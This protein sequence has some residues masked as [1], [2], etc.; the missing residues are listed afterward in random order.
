MSM[1]SSPWLWLWIMITFSAWFWIWPTNNFVG[2]TRFQFAMAYDRMLPSKLT[3]VV[4]RTGT[5][6]Y[7]LALSWVGAL[8]FGV[9]FWYTSFSKLTLDLP[10]FAAIAFGG[11]TLAGGLMPFRA[12]TKRIYQGSVLAKY[13]VGPLPLITFL[14]ALGLLY[15][16]FMIY[17]YAT[18]SRYGVN[19][20]TGLWFVIGLFALAIVFYYGFK[21][22]RRRQGMDVSRTYQEIPSD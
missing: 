13:H 8:I 12:S 21:E 1:V 15:F 16:V 19:S 3:A 4:G 6:I 14:S 11:S 10:L 17:L 18:D 9:L 7:A 22:L 5:P 20:K 2:S